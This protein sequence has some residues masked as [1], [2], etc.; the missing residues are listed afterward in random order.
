M[1]IIDANYAFNQAFPELFQRQSDLYNPT[2]SAFHD[3]VINNLND[4]RFR[5][6]TIDPDTGKVDLA[7]LALLWWIYIGDAIRI[8]DSLHGYFWSPSKNDAYCKPLD[9]D[10]RLYQMLANDPIVKAE[11]HK[12]KDYI[13]HIS[14]VYHKTQNL[15][16]VVLIGR[17]NMPERLHGLRQ[18]IITAVDQRTVLPVK[19]MFPDH[20]QRK[21]YRV[22]DSYSLHDIMETKNYKLL[23]TQNVVIIDDHHITLNKEKLA[24]K[25]IE[26]STYLT[27]HGRCL[28]DLPLYNRGEIRMRS[29][30]YRLIRP[31]ISEPEDGSLV[32]LKDFNSVDE[33][34]HAVVRDVNASDYFQEKGYKF[35][36]EELKL[37]DTDL[38]HFVAA[39]VYLKMSTHAYA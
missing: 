23:G 12:V 14:W 9:Q 1:D 5:N 30:L 15:P 6:V 21:R 31:F 16:K 26:A 19:C 18:V 28:F 4:P 11:Y 33:Y 20:G 27:E 2:E 39:R 25:I 29:E 35:E 17:G 10:S 36:I 32:S 22:I 8:N 34:I 13:L 7:W 37:T 38:D 3:L 24:E